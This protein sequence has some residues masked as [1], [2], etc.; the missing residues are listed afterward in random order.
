MVEILLIQLKKYS[1]TYS[2]EV[3]EIYVA[4]PPKY[5]HNYVMSEMGV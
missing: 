1:D 5:I 3:I 4:R 2:P